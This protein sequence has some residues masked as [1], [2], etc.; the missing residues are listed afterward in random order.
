MYDWKQ[1][2][3]DDEFKVKFKSLEL[4]DARAKYALSEIHYEMKGG[5]SS[6][7]EVLS[8][9]AQIEHIMPQKIKNSPWEEEIKKIKGF[10]TET[11]IDEYKKTNL[12]KLGNLTLLNALKNIKNSNKSF[13]DKKIVYGNSN[14]ITMTQD[15]T[16]QPQWTDEE[17]Q[18]R[19]DGFIPMAVKIWNLKP[20]DDV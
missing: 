9:K 16:R 18:T 20:S 5:R 11:E 10:E 17:I 15:L 6:A 2:P 13:S 12:N 14:E 19:Q 1:Y 8:D 4:S 3:V 7:T